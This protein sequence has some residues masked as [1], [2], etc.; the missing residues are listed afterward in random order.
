MGA[1]RLVASVWL[2]VLVTV[3]PAVLAAAE[4]PSAAGLFERGKAD[5]LAGHYQTGCPAIASSYELEP[6][7]SVL[8]TLAECHAKW[9]RVATASVQFRTYLSMVERMADVLR[10]KHQRRVAFA[11][12]RLEKL[13]ARVPTV[14]F[15]L[16]EGAPSDT[17]VRRDGQTVPP[18]SLGVAIALN[19]GEHQLEVSVPGRTPAHQTLVLREGKRRVV[20]LVVPAA[21]SV[22]PVI[23]PPQP[24]AAPATNP[25]HPVPPAN[26]PDPP[27]VGEH[28]LARGWGYGVGA[29]GLA[30]LTVGLVVGV[31]AI[32]QGETAAEHCPDLQCDAEGM[33]AV[34]SGQTYAAVANVAVAVG[35]VGVVAGGVLLLLARE[36]APASA[37][38]WRPAVEISAR[39]VAAGVKVRW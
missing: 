13:R 27:D 20:V 38:S 6:L 3:C 28:G 32:S 15:R 26:P 7:P 37:R 33:A 18:A 30:S 1:S 24:P 9:G 22:V 17:E 35:A 12:E 36:D 14:S 29:V 25:P 39:S 11:S 21:P 19:P 31:V 23:E 2:A 10:A 34:D 5:M 4:P 8:F 16:P